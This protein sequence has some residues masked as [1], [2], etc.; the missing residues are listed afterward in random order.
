MMG[1]GCWPIASKYSHLPVY[2][3]LQVY[4]GQTQWYD[5]V[6]VYSMDQDEVT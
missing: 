5:R 1:P 6:V 4:Y 2:R 3:L